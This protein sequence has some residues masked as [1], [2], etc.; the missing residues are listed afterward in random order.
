[1]DKFYAKL[2]IGILILASLSFIPQDVDAACAGAGI[3][4]ATPNATITNM[5]DTFNITARHS[6]SAGFD[7]ATFY[8]QNTSVG[9]SS[10]T[11]WITIGNATNNSQGYATINFA[12][13]SLADGNYTLNVSFGNATKSDS[14]WD[15]KILSGLFIENTVPGTTYETTNPADGARTTSQSQSFKLDADLSRQTCILYFG[16]TPTSIINTTTVTPATNGTCILDFS[17]L[18][19][20]AYEYK[21]GSSDGL[22][23]TNTSVRTLN[24]LAKGSVIPQYQAQQ[25]QKTQQTQTFFVIAAIIAAIWYFTKKK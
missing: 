6:I 22:N 8:Y 19:Q 12:T 25:D 4:F 3:N 10:S 24:G 11:T 17:N 7:N 16:I 2:M 21:W 20:S 9:V 15:S 14:C 23:W 5:E 1:M 18:P 13:G